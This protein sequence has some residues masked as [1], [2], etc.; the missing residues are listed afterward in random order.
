MYYRQLGSTDLHVPRI[1]LGAMEGEQA[2]R[3][4]I[5]TGCI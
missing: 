2:A 4:M 1:R 3:T 5:F